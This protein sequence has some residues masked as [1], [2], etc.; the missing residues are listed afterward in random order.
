[1]QTLADWIKA[2][3]A[4]SSKITAYGFLE[5]LIQQKDKR[6]E[7]MALLLRYGKLGDAESVKD[8]YDCV[9]LDIQHC[10]REEHKT[11]CGIPSVWAD[12]TPESYRK[13][14]GGSRIALC[15]SYL[16][17]SDVERELGGWG[18]QHF[19]QDK[20][21]CRSTGDVPVPSKA[22]SQYVLDKFAEE[23]ELSV[24]ELLAY[25]EGYVEN[26]T[27]Q[28]RGGSE[29]ERQPPLGFWVHFRNLTGVDPGDTYGRF[30]SCSC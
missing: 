25:A 20:T 24:D 30:Y 14:V 3:D 16:K 2:M 28:L 4:D 5:W 21:E 17:A 18:M 12:L 13:T 7:P 6:A 11:I 9:Y 22:A 1:M 26:D 23:T 10:Y 19:C 15:D 8:S 29:L 27:M